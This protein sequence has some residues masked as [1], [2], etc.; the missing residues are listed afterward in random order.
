MIIKSS[1]Y[2]YTQ[3]KNGANRFLS[4]ILELINY[5]IY[6]MKCPV[7]NVTYMLRKGDIYLDNK[8]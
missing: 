5:V 3:Y 4:E 8:I 7:F 2:V 6:Q 1:L